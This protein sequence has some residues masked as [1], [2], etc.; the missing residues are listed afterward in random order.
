MYLMRLGQHTVDVTHVD[1]AVLKEA[2][3]YVGAHFI[4]L[5]VIFK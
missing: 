5:N 1:K 2:S 3:V 4:V